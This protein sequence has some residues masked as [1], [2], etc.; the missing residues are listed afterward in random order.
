M[1]IVIVFVQHVAFFEACLFVYS[2]NFPDLTNAS[3]RS[4]YELWYVVTCVTASV[5]GGLYLIIR[6]NLIIVDI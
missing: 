1:K 4:K 2:R 3:Q 5:C 6:K